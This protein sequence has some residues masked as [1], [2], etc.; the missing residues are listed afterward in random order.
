[1][2]I[3]IKEVLKEKVRL[4]EIYLTPGARDSLGKIEIQTLL[5]RHSFGDWGN[6]CPEDD[7]VNEKAL[8]NGG[9]ILSSYTSISG[10]KIWII[11]EGDRSYTTVLLP[12]EY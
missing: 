10:K 4:G 9:R 1:M 2:K 5:M 8:A 12:D 11:T 3:V 7:E 6:V